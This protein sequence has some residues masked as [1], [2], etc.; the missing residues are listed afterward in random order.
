M[1]YIAILSMAMVGFI[2]FVMSIS[3]ARNKNYTVLEVQANTRQAMEIISQKI[4]DAADVKI[5][6]STFGSDPG[7]L[8]LITTNTST[9]PTV[10]DLT[11]QDGSLR[12]TEGTS[13]PIIITAN[14]V[15]VSNLVFYNYTGTSRRDSIGIAATF[16]YYNPGND[17][18][19]NFSQSVRSNI[20][21]H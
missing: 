9:N 18:D 1:V 3:A 17:I 7:K 5:A 4:R 14:K 6:S 12:I 21:L 2:T 11:T 13:S 19:Y 15:L 8:T 20:S 16:S 10:I